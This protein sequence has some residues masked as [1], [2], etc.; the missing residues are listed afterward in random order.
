[1]LPSLTSIRSYIVMYFYTKTNQIH[2]CIKFIFAW[3]GL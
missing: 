1:M 3:V 2:Q